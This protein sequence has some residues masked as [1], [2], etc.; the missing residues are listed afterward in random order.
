MAVQR[1]AIA[2]KTYSTCSLQLAGSQNVAG[3]VRSLSPCSFL[4]IYEKLEQ[5]TPVDHTERVGQNLLLVVIALYL[6]E[7][8]GNALQKKRDLQ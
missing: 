7:K 2:C 8:V 5:T 3:D 4:S 1:Y 6:F